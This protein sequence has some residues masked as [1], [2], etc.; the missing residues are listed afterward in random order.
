MPASYAK[1]HADH[2]LVIDGIKGESEDSKH[3]GAIEV[4]DFSWGN[5]NCGSAATGGGAGAGKV[6]F[7]DIKF[8]TL[9]NI[10]SPLL[11]LACANGKHF[12]KGQLFVRKQGAHQQ[13]YYV[14]SLEDFIVSTYDS[15]GSD[16]GTNSLPE[17]IFTLNFAKIQFEYKRQRPDGTLEAPITMGWDVKQN[18]QI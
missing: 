15:G 11:A 18:K 10:A 16:G 6:Q 17:D 2:L 8:R 3:P 13:D 5:M 1:H 9:A 4:H 7:K 14:I 12:S